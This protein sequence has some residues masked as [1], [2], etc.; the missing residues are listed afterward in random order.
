MAPLIGH[1]PDCLPILGLP[2][3]LRHNSIEIRPVNNPSMGLEC[4]SER[5]GCMPLNLIKKLAMIKFSEEG[6]SKAKIGPKLVLSHQ[7]VRQVVNTKEKFLKDIKG[8]TVVNL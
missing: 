1:S 8:V 7:I 5:K 6:M 4:S 3:F 2:Y